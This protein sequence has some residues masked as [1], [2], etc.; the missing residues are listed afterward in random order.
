[1]LFSPTTA[2]AMV[3]TATTAIWL[4][5]HGQPD[6]GGRRLAYGHLDVPL[7]PVGEAQHQA[8]IAALSGHGF[9]SI[10]SSDLSRCRVLA[11]ALAAA[12]GLDLRL[13][14][15]LREQRMGLWEGRPWDEIQAEG[16]R[17]VND[18]WA[19]YERWCPPEGES[20]LDLDER[21]ERF[22]EEEGFRTRGG[23]H[24]L[25]CHAGVVRVI[26]ARALGLPVAAALRLVP[27]PGS[28][29]RLSFAEA[30]A[31]VERLGEI[32]PPCHDSGP[33]RLDAPTT[34]GRRIAL[35]GS[36]GTGKSTL[37]EALARRLDLPYLPEGM[38]RRLEAG[39]DLHDLSREQ[40]R[41]LLDALWT[42][43]AEQEEQA[44]R[45]WGGFVA[46]R[47]A[48]DHAAFWLLYHF[49]DDEPATD[50]RMEAWRSRVA[51][52]DA[53]VLLPWGELPLVSDGVRSTNR[54]TQRRFQA[55]VEGLLRR[56][57]PAGRLLDLSGSVGLDE[58]V[59]RVLEFLGAGRP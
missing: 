56:D 37:G 2:R 30:G 51:T 43:Q 47:S 50:T 46:D 4:V 39:L 59:R 11:E 19:A 5:R 42:E 33:V 10:S 14:P 44:H 12:R 6:L 13:S 27:A 45:R 54:W 29:T 36:A 32:P 52:Y 57:L 41:D 18:Q 31:V 24:L 38:R 40:F 9:D 23:R 35:S 3:S 20:L 26:V 49:S 17:G 8:V 53:V 1:M 7:S 55:T 58:R 34:G 15:A 48:L 25:V 22:V 28:I 16:G 21:V